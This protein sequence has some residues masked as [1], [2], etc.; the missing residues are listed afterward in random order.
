MLCLSVGHF[1]MQGKMRVTE[2]NLI[3]SDPTCIVRDGA[4]VLRPRV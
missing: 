4:I 2:D 1:V 3:G